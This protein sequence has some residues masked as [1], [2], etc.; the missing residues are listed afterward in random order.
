MTLPEFNPVTYPAPVAYFSM[1]VGLESDMPTYSGGL[2]V[3]AGDRLGELGGL[4]GPEGD[5]Q[6]AVAVVLGGADLHHPERLDLKDR[7]RNHA[8][9]I[10]PDLCHADLLA[11]DCLGCHVRL[12]VAEERGPFTR[13]LRTGFLPAERQFGCAVGFPA[14]RAVTDV[15]CGPEPETSHQVGRPAATSGKPYRRS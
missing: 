6:G 1:E 14:D 7:D 11:D 2:G 5:L 13:T 10:V 15:G 4:L 9:L 12:P 8:V 3:L